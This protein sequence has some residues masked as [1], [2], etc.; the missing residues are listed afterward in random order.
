MLL[1]YRTLKYLKGCEVFRHDTVQINL[2]GLRYSLDQNCCYNK[3]LIAWW[4]IYKLPTNFKIKLR[5]LS[6]W[7]W[8]ATNLTN[9]QIHHVWFFCSEYSRKIDWRATKGSSKNLK[10]FW[11]SRYSFRLF[12]CESRSSLQNARWTPLYDKVLGFK[13]KYLAWNRTWKHDLKYVVRGRKR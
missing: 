11:R 5:Q 10:Y 4:K 12:Y 2:E 13:S 9:L 7:F 6:D 3:T 1:S 8:L